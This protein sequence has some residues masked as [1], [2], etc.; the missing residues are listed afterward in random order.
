MALMDRLSLMDRLVRKLAESAE[1]EELAEAEELVPCMP[2]CQY[3]GKDLL[4]LP[5]PRENMLASKELAESKECTKAEEL[6][7]A[8]E[9]AQLQNREIVSMFPEFA[10]KFAKV[11]SQLVYTCDCQP[12]ENMLASKELAESKECAKA[13]ELFDTFKES[14]IGVE[15]LLQRRLENLTSI[16][17]NLIQCLQISTETVTQTL[18]REPFF[19]WLRIIHRPWLYFVTSAP[20][21]VPIYIGI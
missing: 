18:H 13:E 6:A 14:Q 15:M 2:A 10:T 16:V 5:V 20:G 11:M 3:R 9:L 1:S 21:L 12:R 17:E 19:E 4:E 7:E 8:E